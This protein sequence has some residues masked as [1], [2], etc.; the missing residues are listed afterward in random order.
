MSKHPRLGDC[1]RALRHA[2]GLTLQQVSTRTGLALSTLSKVENHQ[3]SLT[4]D[5]ILQICDGLGIPMTELLT[6]DT[7]A[8]ATRTRVSVAAPANTLVHDTPNYEYSYLSTDLT[9]KR[10]VP[11]IATVR[12]RTLEEFG[13]L[14]K[15][16]GEEFIYV[17]SGEIEVHTEHYAP[18]R[19]AAG[20]SCYIDST[21]GHAYLAVGAGE[22]RIVG[23]CSSQEPR[24]HDVL[25]GAVAQAAD[26]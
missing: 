1:L 3:M 8:A 13:P 5:K 2:H 14:V 19:L 12:A 11:L 9:D 16:P 21:M 18:L 25:V 10:M 22:A 17:V 4:Y 20:Q 7:A 26:G 15:H 6:Q 23:V 24:L